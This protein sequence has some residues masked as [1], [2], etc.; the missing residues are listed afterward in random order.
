MN[1]TKCRWLMIAL[2]ALAV[3]LLNGCGAP[4]AR[5][6]SPLPPPAFSPTSPPTPT[7]TSTPTPAPTF[8]PTSTFTPTP[9]PTFTAT[10]TLAPQPI[11]AQNIASLKLVKE[12]PWHGYHGLLERIAWS[13]NGRYIA[14]QFDDVTPR[15]VVWKANSLQQ[16]ALFSNATFRQWTGDERLLLRRSETQDYVLA[17]PEG[18]SSQHPVDLTCFGDAPIA[19]LRFSPHGRY[20]AAVV[21]KKLMVRSEDNILVPKMVPHHIV[22]CNLTDKNVHHYNIPRDKRAILDVHFGMFS[23]D[24]DWL[25][26]EGDSELP[27][28]AFTIVL[29][30][31][32]K[33]LYRIYPGFLTKL[34]PQGNRV[35]VLGER[36]AVKNA[37]L[38]NP[39]SAF[40]YGIS[41]Y[42]P[43]T[44]ASNTWFCENADFVSQT[45]LGMLFTHQE[46]PFENQLVIRE[47]GSRAITKTIRLP[48][49]KGKA[50]LAF[51]PD[52]S[53]FAVASGDGYLR[54]FD[55]KGKML[56]K[57]RVADL[58]AR[59]RYWSP[60]VALSVSGEKMAKMEGFSAIGIYNLPKDSPAVLLK[61]APR[62]G[63]LSESVWFKFVGDNYLLV[64]TPLGVQMWDVNAQKVVHTY[65]QGSSGW[66]DC[67]ADQ[68]ADKLF[69]RGGFA[70][71]V[72]GATQEIISQIAAS[73]YYAIQPQGNFLAS[74]NPHASYISLWQSDPV[75]RR[76]NLL[77]RLGGKPTG[78]CGMLA[79]SEDGRYLISSAGGVWEVTDGKQVGEFAPVPQEK[80]GYYSPTQLGAGPT[81]FFWLFFPDNHALVVHALPTGEKIREIELPKDTIALRF[82]A[83]RMKLIVVTTDSILIWQAIP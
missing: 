14:G 78:A 45:Q 80:G 1:L 2:F 57:S 38:G 54:V 26:L 63:L 55:M 70:A 23:P 58:V 35:I 50:L 47:I 52:R 16:T 24:E 41:Q 79:F 59:S 37:F 5:L 81:D 28:G 7:P 11:T 61:R 31:H 34:S 64:S 13:P 29:N 36:I 73:G 10:P 42:D 65:M 76:P 69:C 60:P 46:P 18:G 8:T 82:S 43:Q 12:I 15:V 77:L 66:P 32:Q 20:L 3:S 83:D 21:K 68:K 56:N 19:D 27:I 44:G 62:P 53:H 39:F 30:L 40:A 75:R 17:S 71:L 22:V 33:R 48:Q 51:S 67:V 72:D 25:F 49:T 74:C 9:T 4:S 6:S